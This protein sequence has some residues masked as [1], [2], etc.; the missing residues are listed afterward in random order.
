MTPAHK[1]LM[2]VSGATHPGVQPQKNNSPNLDDETPHGKQWWLRISRCFDG[3]WRTM[4]RAPSY[5]GK[6]WM[7]RSKPPLG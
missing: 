7:V 4:V 6:D 3:G 2:F 5:L 1:R